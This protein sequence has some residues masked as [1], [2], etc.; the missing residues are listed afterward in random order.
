MKIDPYLKK[1]FKNTCEITGIV[2]DPDCVYVGHS[3]TSGHQILMVILQSLLR[4]LF[5]KVGL[6]I[7]NVTD[8][9]IGYI[10]NTDGWRL[11]LTYQDTQNGN[12]QYDIHD[13]VT[14]NDN[15]YNIWKRVPLVLV[16]LLNINKI[17]QNNKK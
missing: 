8:P 13:T 4:K 5:S 14:P 15:I 12:L 2:S 1:G 10:L 16:L 17:Q 11:Q 3:T 7:T 9:L 6:T